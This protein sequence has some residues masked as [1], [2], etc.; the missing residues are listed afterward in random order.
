VIVRFVDIIGMDDH[1]CLTFIF[2]IHLNRFFNSNNVQMYG[3]KVIVL[4]KPNENHLWCAIAPV[5]T[6]S[7][8]NSPNI[9]I[10][11]FEEEIICKT[12]PKVNERQHEIIQIR[13]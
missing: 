3:Y 9:H 6:S 13:T 8:T 7:Y 1:Y 10:F 4:T 11:T 5:L 12:N 2:I